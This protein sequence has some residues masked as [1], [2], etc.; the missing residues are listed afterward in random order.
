[1]QNMP[2]K[3]QIIRKAKKQKAISHGIAPPQGRVAYALN[4]AALQCRAS[5]L[6][7]VS[8]GGI[9]SV[10]HTFMQLPQNPNR[11]HF[12]EHP[13]N[14]IGHR[15]NYVLCRKNY[16]R[17]NSN[18]IRPFF[19]VYKRLISKH[20]QRRLNAWVKCCFPVVCPICTDVRHKFQTPPPPPNLCNAFATARNGCF[21]RKMYVFF[22]ACYKNKQ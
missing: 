2:H 14:Y 22:F 8:C 21:Q 4:C 6:R 16:I 17:H 10:C 11:T 9:Q 18:Y 7:C 3:E 1:M 13:E 19:A 12:P 5:G 20:L 15:K